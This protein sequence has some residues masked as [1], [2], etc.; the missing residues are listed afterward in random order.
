MAVNSPQVYKERTFHVHGLAESLCT[1]FHFVSPISFHMF[2]EGNSSAIAGVQEAYFQKLQNSR[3]TFCD[4]A[5][6]SA[7]FLIFHKISASCSSKILLIPLL[8]WKCMSL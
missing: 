6:A 8:V 1:V 5:S 2:K 3:N 4:S 7:S